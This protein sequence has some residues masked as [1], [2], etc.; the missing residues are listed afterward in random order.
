VSGGRNTI[1]LF[2]L[3][4]VLAAYFFIFE[5]GKT[6]DDGVERV[7]DL[8]LEKV[9]QVKVT[10][11]GDHTIIEK[12]PL[13]G[14]QI[15]DPLRYPADPT[16][17]G[18]LLNEFAVLS[19]A[20][21]VAD[22]AKDLSEYG[23]ESPA[24][25]I[26][27]GSG[28]SN[29]NVLLIGDLNPTGSSYYAAAQGSRR[30]FF[31]AAETNNHLRKSTDALRDRLLI[32]FDQDKVDE[33]VI[34]RRGEKLV[35]RLDSLGI[36]RMYE[37]FKLPAER[38]EAISLIGNM[39]AAKALTFVDDA[40]K[41]LKPYGLDRPAVT[42]TIKSKD[43]QINHTI[44]L[45]KVE[46]GKLYTMSSERNTVYAVSSQF[47]AQID[48]DSELFRRKTAFNFRSY[49]VP[50]LTMRLGEDTISLVK[51][52]FEDWRIVAPFE[53][54]A[55]DFILNSL[56]DSLE[57][58]KVHKYIPASAANKKR[59]GLDQAPVMLSLTVDNRSIPQDIL[60]GAA[61]E[62]GRTIHV[63]DPT[64]EW[65]Y[66]VSSTGIKDLPATTSDVR[67][68]K[69]MRFKGYQVHM[70]ELV[71][72]DNRVRLRRDQ[73]EKTVW[74]LEEPV[75][76]SADAVTV[77]RA[78]SVLDS[79]YADAFITADPDA[80]IA[81]YGLDRPYMEVTMQIGGRDD[82]PEERLSL[83]VGKPFPGDRRL[84]YVKLRNSSVIS[85]VKSG[86]VEH[87]KNMVAATP[88]S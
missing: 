3:L 25:T 2:A 41:S 84:V 76:Q 45:G 40:P 59:Y 20:R 22:S 88:T 32:H 44:S 4:G 54:R 26:E 18:A 17:L 87:L 83:L 78:F 66:E 56:L 31:I 37:P 80:D 29:P 68:K 61:S 57:V 75:S 74:K 79:L 69:I 51:R 86:F 7:F 28:L 65:I 58:M 60:I 77:G 14:W 39:H 46:G 38:N 30:V 33:F 10:T 82:V 12:V 63:Q 15:V 11:G 43:G 34:Q 5:S 9:T 1:L 67:D 16:A 85:L 13:E 55:S 23:L 52:S 64:E 49:E 35:G 21:T 81:I 42:A 50:K 70:F 8:E 48:R 47:I 24:A 19:P 62:D 6:E 73:K 72:P 71:L 36:W 53:M 27:L